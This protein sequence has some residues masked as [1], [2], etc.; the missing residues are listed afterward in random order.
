MATSRTRRARC[1]Q[2]AGETDGGPSAAGAVLYDI[3]WIQYGNSHCRARG[4]VYYYLNIQ[5]G[6]LSRRKGLKVIQWCEEARRDFKLEWEIEEQLA[7][8]KFQAR[9]TGL[10]PLPPFY[11][12]TRQE[13]GKAGVFFD[14]SR[15]KDVRE[16]SGTRQKSGRG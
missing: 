9:A 10:Y 5:L 8:R 6:R 7:K 2:S 13:R 16:A 1:F 3:M 12:S 15:Q 4:N 14:F 11:P